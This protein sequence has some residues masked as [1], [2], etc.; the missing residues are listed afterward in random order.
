MRLEQ[1]LL[2]RTL[3]HLDKHEHSW[4]FG[5]SDGV[6]INVECPW[7]IIIDGSI[8]IAG[9]DDGQRFGLPEPV[10]AAALGMELLAAKPVIA[11]LPGV[12][13]GD[14]AIQFE[15]G[16][17]LQVVANSAGYEAWVLRADDVL[18]VGRGDDRIEIQQG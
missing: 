8:R 3:N 4:G 13:A 14:L 10:D 15:G 5:F 18:V 17:I 7:R 11:L 6:S 1:V 12:V 2:G 16:P 9:D